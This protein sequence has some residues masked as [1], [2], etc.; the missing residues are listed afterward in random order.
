MRK[1]KYYDRINHK[2][3]ELEVSDE[4]AKFLQADNRRQSRQGQK[5][6]ENVVLSLD[7]YSQVDGQN[8][9]TYHE[10]IADEKSNT[11][12]NYENKQ[13]NKLVWHICHKLPY[14]ERQILWWYY[15][16]GYKASEIAKSLKLDSSQ[17]S[18]QK[19]T[20]INHL[21]NLLIC[22][23]E[24]ANTDYYINSVFRDFKKTIYETAKKL[25]LSNLKINLI[26]LLELTKK[27]PQVIK[28]NAKLGIEL[29]EDE[30]EKSLLANKEV[31]NLVKWFI[32]KGYE[33]DF[34]NQQELVK[35]LLEYAMETYNKDKD[36]R[37]LAKFKT[38]SPSLYGV[39]NNKDYIVKKVK[40]FYL[41][42]Y[43]K[44]HNIKR[45]KPKNKFLKKKNSR[46]MRKKHN[47]NALRHKKVT[48]I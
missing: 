40:P 20:A 17:F 38:S 30:K 5:Y 35:H 6:R 37:F 46:R 47:L 42:Q 32:D 34:S 7:D 28:T 12:E 18:Q 14:K 26:D 45:A 1:I 13:F 9:L 48:I 16:I 22:D 10:L 4:V 36:K 43:K 25:N 8:Y 19:A 27:V 3:L 11:I 29:N 2:M 33:F 39:M 31:R 24:F 41:I 15:K 21:R 44:K 23:K